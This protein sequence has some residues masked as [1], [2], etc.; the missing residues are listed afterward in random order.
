M[1]RFPIKI[2]RAPPGSSLVLIIN[3]CFIFSGKIPKYLKIQML[4]WCPRNCSLAV[5]AK[6]MDVRPIERSVLNSAQ[7][8]LRFCVLRKKSMAFGHELLAHSRARAGL[9]MHASKK[10][11]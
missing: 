2:T 4:A 6:F 3:V 7:F 9:V 10:A 8:H 1:L 11:A 5:A